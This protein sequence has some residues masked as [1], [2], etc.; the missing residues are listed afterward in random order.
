VDHPFPLG[1]LV[2]GIGN[3]IDVR[4]FTMLVTAIE[5]FTAAIKAAG[6]DIGTSFFFVFLLL[7]TTSTMYLMTLGVSSIILGILLPQNVAFAADTTT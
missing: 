3:G 5:Y 4:R 6:A 1:V 7:L 2:T